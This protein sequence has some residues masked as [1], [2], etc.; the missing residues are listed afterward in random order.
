MSDPDSSRAAGW[1]GSDELAGAA[2]LILSL[3]GAAAFALLFAARGGLG[4]SG[5]AVG[6]LLLFSLLPIWISAAAVQLFQRSALSRGVA[7]FAGFALALLLPL[8]GLATGRLA[9]PV[10]ALALLAAVIL[11][12][13]PLWRAVRRRPWT[14]VLLFIPLAL[15]LIIFSAPTRL[16]LPESLALGLAQADNYFDIAIAQ[17]LKHYGAKCMCCGATSATP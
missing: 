3:C 7:I 2:A 8:L 17:M 11:V 1:R 15:P 14:I 5:N 10:A 9:A 13:A 6:L 4:D 12:W 16:F